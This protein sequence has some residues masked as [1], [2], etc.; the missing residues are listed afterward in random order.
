MF[1]L[2][3]IDSALEGFRI[4]RERPWAVGVWAAW[5][6]VG[7][8]LGQML[9]TL[10][11]MQELSKLGQTPPGQFTPVQLAALGAAAARVWPAML[12]VT[13]LSYGFTVVVYTA[14]VRAV[15]AP[16]VR[17][18]LFFLRLGPD[19]LRQLLLALMVLGVLL[20]Y[21]VAV[22]M[23]VALATATGPIAGP[24]LAAFVLASAVATLIVVGVRLSL[25]P[26]ATF[27]ARRVR[28]F[29]TWKMTRG[30]SWPLIGVYAT[31]LGLA[32]VIYFLALVIVAALTSTLALVTGGGIEA[33]R[34]MTRP[35]ATSLPALFAWPS[36]IAMVLSAA[37]GTPI[38][39]VTS[40]AGVAA[41][42]RIAASLGEPGAV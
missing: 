27:A 15:F 30:L 38:S 22:Q 28:L 20:G 34:A 8:V 4:T 41:Y 13:V 10:P 37:V 26:A 23:L 2:P 33:I 40:A 35:A 18:R 17:D 6:L 11:G 14:V 19:E 29:D 9:L 39:V 25:A 36:V 31:A 12:A 32:A 16:Q 1:R 42:R 24:P 5:L 7:T 21:A 3:I